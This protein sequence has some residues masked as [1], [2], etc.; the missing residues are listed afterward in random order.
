[1]ADTKKDL[2]EE[3]KT[4]DTAQTVEEQDGKADEEKEDPPQ[5]QPQ[6]AMSIQEMLM[7]VLTNPEL[8]KAFQEFFQQQQA[9]KQTVTQ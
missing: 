5:E 4:E 6:G 9:A 3:K 7:G 8:S 1:M 2:E